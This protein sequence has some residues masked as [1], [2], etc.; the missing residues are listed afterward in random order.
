MLEFLHIMCWGGVVLLTELVATAEVEWD[1]P[2][3]SKERKGKGREHP[4]TCVSQ[5]VC[6]MKDKCWWELRRRKGG[7][8]S[9]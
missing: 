2:M 1:E 4:K 6:L 5:A 7:G 3:G 8:V 9:V